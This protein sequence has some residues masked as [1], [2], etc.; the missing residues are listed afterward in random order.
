MS[1][2][3]FAVSL[4]LEMLPASAHAGVAVNLSRKWGASL[5]LATPV[6]A[7]VAAGGWLA[8]RREYRYAALAGAVVTLLGLALRA[9]FVG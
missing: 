8:L 6:V 9:G 4:V 7:L 3:L 2:A 1:G 5:L